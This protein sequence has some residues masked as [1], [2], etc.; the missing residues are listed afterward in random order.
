MGTR[1]RIYAHSPRANQTQQSMDLINDVNL[2]D[3]NY[4]QQAATSFA[5]RLNQNFFLGVNDWQPST[6]IYEHIEN[7]Q[8]FKLPG[9]PDGIITSYRQ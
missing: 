1:Y 6:E 2:T 8:Q 9:G 3:P 5:N 7:N 4:A